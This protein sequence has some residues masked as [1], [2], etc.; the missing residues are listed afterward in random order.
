MTSEHCGI[1]RR[2]SV[3]AACGMA[4][5]SCAASSRAWGQVAQ[6]GAGGLLERMARLRPVRYVE[7]TGVEESILYATGERRVNRTE[8]RWGLMCGSSAPAWTEAD[9]KRVA[10]AH[11]AAMA[12]A[13]NVIVIDTP[14]AGPG[15]RG[16]AF[17]IV[18]NMSTVNM[19]A[20]APGAFA[21]AEAYLETK[22][23]DPVT[24]TININWSDLG[25]GIIGQTGSAYRADIAYADSRAGLIAGQDNNDTI[26][27]FLPAGAT[28]P[29]RFD[30]T[31][32]TVTDVGLIDWTSAAYRS[33]IGT[34]NGSV[35]NM[36]YN[37]SFTFDFDPSNGVGG[38]LSLVDTIVHE[39]GHALG[40]TSAVDGG[41]TTSINVLDLYRFARVDRAGIGDTNPD[42][43]AEFGT[44]A[45]EVDYDN[46]SNN[47]VISD[48]IS[49]EWRMSDGTPYQ[50][51]HFHQQSC[52]P[53]SA[54]GIMQPALCPGSTFF[55]NYFKTSDYLMLDAIGWD[56][57]TCPVP[58]I[59]V[60]PQGVVTCLGSPLSLSVTAT[61][62]TISYQWRKDAVNIPGA[63][64]STYS[65]ASANASHSGTYDVVA[66]NSCGSRTSAAA[67]VDISSGPTIQDQPDDQVMC[68]TGT[69]RFT[70]V[71]PALPAPTYQW[72]KNLVSID[73]AT[74]A[75]LTILN[76]QGSDQGSFDCVVTTSCGTTTSQA[77]TLSVNQFVGITTQPV[78]QTACVGSSVSFTAGASG[79][80]DEYQWRKGGNNIPGATG[81]T[82][83]ISGVVAGDAG[84]YDCLIAGPCG[85]NNTDPAYL[86]VVPGVQFVTHPSSQSS[87]EGAGVNLTASA[88]GSPPLQW[89]K[90]GVAIPGAT[91]T[92]YT[93]PILNATTAGTYDVVASSACGPVVSNPAVITLQSLPSVVTQPSNTTGCV[94]QSFAFSVAASAT[95]TYQ[96]R[97]NGVSIGGA[98]LPT[99]SAIATS[100][101]EGTYDCVLSNACGETV[102]NA[103]TLVLGTGPS[104]SSAPPDFTVSASSPV[105]ITAVAS[106]TPPISYQWRRDGVAISEVAPYSGTSTSSLTI[107]SVTPEVVG[108]FDVVA[109][110]ACGSATSAP[111]TVTIDA[112]CPADLD[113]GSGLGT[114][115][116][117]VDINDLLYFLTAFEA[118]SAAADLDNGTS[119]GTPDGGVDINDLLYF[120]SHFEQGC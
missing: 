47:D 82:L 97:R 110:D 19:P 14:Q 76:V 15:T 63:T 92:S 21:L 53:G 2:L 75:T 78:P 91:G 60:P 95:Q 62:G 116:G 25:S 24:L 114:P 109:T 49:N 4:L 74:G 8:T 18:F 108:E 43:T 83:T 37:S 101:D 20:S 120:L 77:A 96:W 88:S 26:E 118:G 42:T 44:T 106:G 80:I 33:T 52:T 119:N 41:G 111:S 117:G 104:F 10:E 70:V 38:N 5:M 100:N 59:S 32:A 40:F 3:I 113:N 30:A 1:A 103:A 86:T 31:S 112:S 64:G 84:E 90:G 12:D 11:H 6:D 16:P 85:N 105:V 115:D 87:C 36:T 56:D 23:A 34:S 107:A 66:T 22:F 98:N 57:T 50:A 71:V 29:V 61:N 79:S 55:P 72:R 13:A 67:V 81:P 94:G 99:F 89:R 93:I 54:T 27:D 48:I 17:N 51:S 46:P 9:L 102:S 73:G 58:Y 45:R 65:V 68:A 39:V 35:A 7:R 69:A 28:V